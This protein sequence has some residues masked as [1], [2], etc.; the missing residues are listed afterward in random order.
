[1]YHLFL[2]D[3]TKKVILLLVLIVFVDIFSGG[4]LLENMCPI[5][6]SLLLEKI[7]LIIAALIVIKL[8]VLTNKKKN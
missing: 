1:M 3:E 4:I 8:G 5:I 7:M 6:L 2:K